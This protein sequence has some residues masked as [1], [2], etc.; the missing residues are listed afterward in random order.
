MKLVLRAR[1]RSSSHGTSGQHALPLPANKRL[2]VACFK[3]GDR[4]R[5]IS[6]A[7]GHHLQTGTITGVLNTL[8]APVNPETARV[9]LRSYVLQELLRGYALQ[10]DSGPIEFFFAR[11]LEDDV[12]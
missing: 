12:R 5:V 10:L 11:D 3:I 1:K 7:S 4:V 2:P 8:E 9:L 6:T